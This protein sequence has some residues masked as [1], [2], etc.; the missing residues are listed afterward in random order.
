MLDDASGLPPE[1]ARPL[2][3]WLEEAAGAVKLLLVPVDD[4]R[5]ED[6]VASLGND[7]VTLSLHVLMTADETA[8]YVQGRLDYAGAFDDV[9]AVFDDEALRWLHEGSGGNP[10][11]VH[12]RA[13]LLMR[14]STPAEAER[15]LAGQAWDDD[16]GTRET[17]DEDT[18]QAE[19]L[20]PGDEPG[21]AEVPEPA[22]A[23]VVHPAPSASRAVSRGGRRARWALLA[24]VVALVFAG[25]LAWRALQEAGGVSAQAERAVTFEEPMREPPVVAPEPA[26]VEPEPA[27]QVTP[28]ADSAGEDPVV[29]GGEELALD[30]SGAAVEETE[31]RR[32]RRVAR[33]RHSRRVG[34]PAR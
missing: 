25:L 24:G 14:G 21:A 11:E 8:A 26:A 5:A 19:V 30:E 31:P 13:L 6:L 7:V 12:H 9:V 32:A 3:A 4:S 29:V 33:S 34:G 10:R 18:V 16:D 2:R 20:P 23:P 17:V 22:S 15:F 1:A 27:T 28:L